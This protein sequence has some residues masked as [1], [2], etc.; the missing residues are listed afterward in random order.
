MV[1]CNL[2]HGAG[3]NC[4]DGNLNRLEVGTPWGNLIHCNGMESISLYH[5]RRLIW[6]FGSNRCSV[7]SS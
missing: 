6:T 2:S 1:L 7:S 5:L 4:I 3:T